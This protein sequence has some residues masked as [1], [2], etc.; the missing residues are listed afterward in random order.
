MTAS[1]TPPRRCYSELLHK[2]RVMN[3]K[4][5]ATDKLLD[6]AI[7]ELVKAAEAVV[8]ECR[9]NSRASLLDIAR[10]SAA[11]AAVKTKEDA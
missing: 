4:V 3:T 8:E 6:A 5:S 10:L 2:E 11:L 1:D 9:R 7:G